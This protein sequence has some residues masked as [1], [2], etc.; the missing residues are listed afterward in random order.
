MSGWRGMSSVV[1]GDT[2]RRANR[3]RVIAALRRQGAMTRAALA[4]VG[5]SRSTA[6]SVIEELAEAGMVIDAVRR[7]RY[8]GGQKVRIRISPRRRFPS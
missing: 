3:E 1:S 6:Q 2:Q 7:I 5:L 4:D 8:A